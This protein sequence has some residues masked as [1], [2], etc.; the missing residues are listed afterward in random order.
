MKNS[1][2]NN[3]LCLIYFLH[4]TIRMTGPV[5]PGPR[6]CTGYESILWFGVPSGI[7]SVAEI[8]CLR[9]SVGDQAE[10]GSPS[11][12]REEGLRAGDYSVVIH[13]PVFQHGE[14][15]VR[16]AVCLVEI[17]DHISLGH[18]LQQRDCNI[19]ELRNAVYQVRGFGLEIVCH[20]PCWI[21]LDFDIDIPVLPSAI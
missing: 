14:M 8:H 11:L 4:I 1:P 7:A 21:I 18:L 3:I 13:V 19:R 6:G 10:Y 15:H 16:S 17:A 9:E 5:Q 20:A 2:E 12:R